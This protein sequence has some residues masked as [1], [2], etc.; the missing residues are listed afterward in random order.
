MCRETN[1]TVNGKGPIRV[2]SAGKSGFSI[3]ISSNSDVYKGSWGMN[4]QVQLNQRTLNTQD[5]ADNSL[6]IR[7]EQRAIAF[8]TTLLK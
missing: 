6:P 7:V 2:L 5:L 4:G 1:R 8:Y 3:V